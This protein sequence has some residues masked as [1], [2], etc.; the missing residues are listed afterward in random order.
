VQ[1][2][3]RRS[4]KT[5][6]VPATQSILDAVQAAGIDAPAAC[7]TGT[8]GTCAVKVLAGEPDH[9][10]SVLS[11]A[12]RERAGLMCICVSRAKTPELTL[13]L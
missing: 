1:V 12:E 4:G 7:R 6:T 2:S 11:Q 13:D 10:D 3:L 8:C 5:L 9:R